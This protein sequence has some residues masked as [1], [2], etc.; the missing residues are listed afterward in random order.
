[1]QPIQ[2]TRYRWILPGID[3]KRQNQEILSGQVYFLFVGPSELSI[4]GLLWKETADGL[5][6]P[7]GPSG[8]LK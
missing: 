2:Q 7:L 8:G 6:G 3:W 4:F 1:M 5:Q